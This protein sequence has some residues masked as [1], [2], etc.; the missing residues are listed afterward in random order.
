VDVALGT[1]VAASFAAW[2]EDSPSAMRLARTVFWLRVLGVDFDPDNVIE[3][4]TVPC[5]VLAA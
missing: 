1:I 4:E 2:T 3:A 5:A